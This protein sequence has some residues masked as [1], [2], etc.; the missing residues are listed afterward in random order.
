MINSKLRA[1][2][3]ALCLGAGMSLAAQPA[4]AATSWLRNCTVI[5]ISETDNFVEIQIA[6]NGTTDW[7]SMASSSSL[8]QKYLA[9]ATAAYLSGKK[10]DVK[11]DF[12]TT[13]CG[14]TQSNCE[15]VLGWFIHN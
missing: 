2:G 7:L 6:L 15:N 13:G 4:S 1:I 5:G 12:A 3:L 10:L 8:A 11:V 9:S 14:T